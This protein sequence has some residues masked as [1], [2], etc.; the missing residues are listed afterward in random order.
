MISPVI[1]SAW[2]RMVNRVGQEMG[3]R[4]VD[5]IMTCEK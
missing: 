1:V 5:L 3:C 2:R 4:W